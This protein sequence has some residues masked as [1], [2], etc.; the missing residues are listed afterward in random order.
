[1]TK[2]RQ[3]LILKDVPR[4]DRYIYT[5]VRPDDTRE[6]FTTRLAAYQF[7]KSMLPESELPRLTSY[8]QYCRDL[9]K[10]RHYT[11]ATAKRQ[12]FQITATPV[13]K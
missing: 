1:M 11:L 6:H 13:K 2:T 7:L 4:I 9:N 5:L 3:V 12:V 10:I 8:S